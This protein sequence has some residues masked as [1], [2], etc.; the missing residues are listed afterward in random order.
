MRTSEERVAEMHRRMDEMKRAKARRRHLLNGAAACA[1]CLAAAVPLALGM[2]RIPLR[3][4]EMP[5]GEAAASIFAGDSASG[6]IVTALTAFVLGVLVTVFCFR[7]RGHMEERSLP[8]PA[9][10]AGGPRTGA[11]QSG[12]NAG[13]TAR[14]PRTEDE[15]DDRAD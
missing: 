5:V 2:S 10:E 11:H 13:E 4:R 7:L 15:R 1:V 8:R 14:P 9:D 3:A 6:I 12:A